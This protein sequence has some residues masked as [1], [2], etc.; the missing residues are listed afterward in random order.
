MHHPHLQDALDGHEKGK[1]YVLV[2]LTALLTLSLLF[3]PGESHKSGESA[4][5]PS[6]PP[7]PP[8]ID[9]SRVLDPAPPVQTEGAP[10]G[11]DQAVDAALAEAMRS[12]MQEATGATSVGPQAEPSEGLF[13]RE[14]G[15]VGASDTPVSPA[16]TDEQPATLALTAPLNEVSTA[17]TQP[18][19]EVVTPFV[20][21]QAT[22]PTASYVSEPRQARGEAVR[23]SSSVVTSSGGEQTLVVTE[24]RIASGADESGA[25]T[26]RVVPA[27]PS[28][29]AVG[30]EDEVGQNGRVPPV[31]VDPAS[32]DAR[33]AAYQEFLLRRSAMEKLSEGFRL[34]AQGHYTAAIES[35]RASAEHD[36]SSFVALRELGNTYLYSLGE[37]DKAVEAYSA[38]ALRAIEAGVM[39]QAMMLIDQVADLD[40]R[41]AV[42]LRKAFPPGWP[43]LTAR[44]TR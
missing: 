3:S 39:G 40:P 31:V 25:E 13:Q 23:V 10:E 15:L 29:A 20:V 32:V 19:V 34:R 44:P 12:A 43:D 17:S 28:V 18:P 36:P 9:L 5:P 1:H 4:Q 26:A 7:S 21:P 33:D 11:S 42:E 35:L 27:A 41:Q 38:A 30:V 22:I 14:P 16:V 2:G 6:T 37:R 8:A 24:E